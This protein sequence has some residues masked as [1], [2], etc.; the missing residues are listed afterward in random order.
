M[1]ENRTAYLITK[2]IE[3]QLMK[4]MYPEALA[5][6]KEQLPK[7]KKDFGNQSFQAVNLYLL[8]GLAHLQQGNDN[9]AKLMIL[10][11][12]EAYIK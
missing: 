1:Y 7:F 2:E 6:I 12:G 5:Q 11:Y 4:K 8:Y 9:L 10:L 3:L